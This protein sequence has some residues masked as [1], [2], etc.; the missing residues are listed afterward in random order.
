MSNEG[1]DYQPIGRFFISFEKG[2]NRVAL[3]REQQARDR[4]EAKAARRAAA[5]LLRAAEADIEK[6]IRKLKYNKSDVVIFELQ[7]IAGNLKEQREMLEDPEC[8]PS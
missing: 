5:E 3:S 2:S 1:I 6:A 4:S 7:G 8:D